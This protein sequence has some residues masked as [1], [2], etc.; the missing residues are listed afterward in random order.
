MIAHEDDS[1]LGN[2][3]LLKSVAGVIFLGTPHRGSG[4]ASLG[5]LV[6][7]ITNAFLIS[8]SAGLQ[9]KVIRTDLLRPL[10]YDSKAL[11]EL[12][13]SVRNRLAGLQIVSF[14]ETKPEPPSPS[15]R[16]IIPE[17]TCHHQLT[18]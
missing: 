5:A 1:D 3:R 12:T 16:D 14:Y 10:Q 17:R 4:T 2:Q 8:V 18:S 15:V 9:T 6:G 7:R 11:Q 13:D